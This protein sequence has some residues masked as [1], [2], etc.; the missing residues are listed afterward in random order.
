MKKI[1]I[2]SL[3]LFVS[4][5]GIIKSGP[6]V[7]KFQKIFSFS[8]NEDAKKEII[9][10]LI[11]EYNKKEKKDGELERVGCTI[12]ALKLLEK[13]FDNKKA[14]CA[15]LKAIKEVLTDM[16]AKNMDSPK[17]INTH[18]LITLIQQLNGL[19]CDVVTLNITRSRGKLS[20]SC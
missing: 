11:S 14:V 7:E 9:L 1:L 5:I 12:D 10:T 4:S 17:Y 3:F 19:A 13:G 18:I 2:L 16:L 8:L 20:G 6:L 15:T